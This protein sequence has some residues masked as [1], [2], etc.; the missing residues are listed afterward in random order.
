MAPQ[1][2]TVTQSR[3]WEGHP[4]SR[5]TPILFFLVVVEYTEAIQKQTQ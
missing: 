2:E 5:G 1:D 3:V 4:R